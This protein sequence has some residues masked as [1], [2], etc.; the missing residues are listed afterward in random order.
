[1]GTALGLVGV[2]LLILAQGYFVAAEFAFV[3]VRRAALERQAAAGSKRAERAI[4][5]LGRLSFML[6]GAQLGITVTSLVVGFIAEPTLGEALQP[7]MEWIGVGESAQRGVAIAVAFVLATM[8][9]MIL[10][11]L[12]PKNLAIARAEGVS[13]WLATSVLMYTR[14]ASPLIKLFDN[15]ANGLLRAVGIE[16]IE[17]LHGGVTPDELD[18]IVEESAQSRA[19][20]RTAGGAAVAIVGVRRPRC[21]RRDEAP[22]RRDDRQRRRWRRRLALGGSRRSQ[23]AAGGGRRR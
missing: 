4:S 3:A 23:Q 2:L 15:S 7:V 5:V 20:H 10:G 17:E 13:L 12:A 1:M 19:S 6:S 8:A 18:Y 14:I 21:G 9:Q 11:E 22:R 16:P